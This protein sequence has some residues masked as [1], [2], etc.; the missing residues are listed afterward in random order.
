[1]LILDYLSEFYEFFSLNLSGIEME[2]GHYF[3][4]DDQS[5][6]YKHRSE[7]RLLNSGIDDETGL[8]WCSFTRPI[9]PETPLDLDLT[10]NLYHFYFKGDFKDS[11]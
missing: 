7:I 8:S 11:R 1:M 4:E 9:R 10:K 2:L 5:E 6:P 3:L